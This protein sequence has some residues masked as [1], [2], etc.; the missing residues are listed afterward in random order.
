MNIKICLPPRK[1]PMTLNDLP[2]MSALVPVGHWQSVK[3]FG[4]E[5]FNTW[6]M[7]VPMNMEH[8]ANRRRT[9]DGWGEWQTSGGFTSYFAKFQV[10]APWTLEGVK[11]VKGLFA[12]INFSAG[13]ETF[14]A[15]YALYS[16]GRFLSVG[17]A[18]DYALNDP[19]YHSL[20]V[21]QETYERVL[22]VTP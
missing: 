19:R 15:E 3:A 16:R 8:T 12:V 6:I 7:S 18:L 10:E 13:H 2:D 22:E 21:N 5:G 17:A 1:R 4:D 20:I 9:A 11:E 14:R